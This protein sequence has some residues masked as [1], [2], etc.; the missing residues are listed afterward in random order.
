MAIGLCVHVI[1]KVPGFQEQSY[2]TDFGKE[3]FLAL[4]LCTLPRKALT[5]SSTCYVQNCSSFFTVGAT[6]P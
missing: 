1:Y 5:T 4:A 2:R 3:I 6:N